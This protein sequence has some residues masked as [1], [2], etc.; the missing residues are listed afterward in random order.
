VSSLF[1]DAFRDLIL[2]EGGYAND[3]RDRGG[4]T[5]YGIT[6]AVA[7]AHGYAGPMSTLPLD[8]AR[9]IYRAAYW[10]APGLEAVAAAAPSVAL[11]LFDTAVNMGV[12]VAGRFLQTALNALNR[13][14]QDYPDLDVDGRVGP[15]TVAA[16]AAYLRARGAAGR[17]VLL[18]ALN[19]QQAARY[20]A[21]A[22]ADPAQEAFVYGWLLNRVA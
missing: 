16:L 20:L 22:A 12:R 8:E 17:T 1:D 7:R 9:R 5:R 3:P 6:A 4:E 13:G 14:G 18:R 2:V 11:E 19:G 15:T 21:I 10:D